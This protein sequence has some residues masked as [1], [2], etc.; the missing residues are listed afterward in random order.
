MPHDESIVGLE[1]LSEFDIA[2]P[3][4]SDT[5][6]PSKSPNGNLVP[7]DSDRGGDYKRIEGYRLGAIE[8]ARAIKDGGRNEEP[9]VFPFIHCWRHHLELQLKILV[10][11]SANLYADA[12]PDDLTGTHSLAKIWGYA[13][14]Y[15]LRTFSNDSSADT[16]VPDRIIAQF[17]QIDPDGVAPRYARTVTGRPSV[18][19]ELWIEIEPFHT[20]MLNLSSYL[21]GAIEGTAWLH[22]AQPT[23]DELI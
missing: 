10:T 4:H 5:L 22:D 17:S 21:T 18:R 7:F 16:R 13:K 20:S 12:L 3:S 8:L 11:D 19:R 1:D 14:P 6:R 23:L 2:W 9:L 15:I